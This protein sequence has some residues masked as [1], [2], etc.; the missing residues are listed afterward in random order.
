MKVIVLVSTLLFLSSL[1]SPL[2]AEDGWH[3]GVVVLKNHEVINGELK[4]DWRHNVIQVKRGER[5]EAYS[6]FQVALFYFHDERLKA[7]RKYVSLPFEA[8]SHAFVDVFFE[9][10]IRGEMSMLRKENPGYNWNQPTPDRDIYTTSGK[11]IDDYNYHH[12]LSF[13]YFYSVKGRLMP[14]EDFE[15]ELMASLSHSETDRISR[16]IAQNSIDL[17]KVGDQVRVIRFYN[18]SRSSSQRIFLETL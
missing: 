9:E 6:A 3:S 10:V 12:A 8:R 7:V 17:S 18:K 5:T 4:H 11:I 1:C 16:F 13:D 14:M 15:D 2:E